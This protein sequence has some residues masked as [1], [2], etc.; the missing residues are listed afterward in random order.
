[1]KTYVLTDLESYYALKYIVY[2]VKGSVYISNTKAEYKK[3]Y[4]LLSLS[5]K[6]FQGTIVKYTLLG[7]THWWTY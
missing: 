7:S 5:V 2:T 3:V 4:V 1:M 6:I